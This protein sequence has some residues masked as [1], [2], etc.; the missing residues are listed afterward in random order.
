[1]GYSA[2]ALALWAVN[3]LRFQFVTS[4]HIS[5]V[6]P[7]AVGLLLIRDVL[8]I[9]GQSEKTAL[10]LPQKIVIGLG[11]TAVLAAVAF[12]KL[13]P[14]ASTI[15]LSDGS[16]LTL[17]HVSYEQKNPDVRARSWL[18]NAQ[19]W[20]AKKLDRPT[21][22]RPPV[23]NDCL[24]YW[25]S[26][27]EK[28]T[29]KYLGFDW[30]SHAV[31]VDS[32]GCE[33]HTTPPMLLYT[34]NWLGGSRPLPQ[35]PPGAKYL[36]ISGE[37]PVFPRREKTFKLRVYGQR[38][39]LAGEFEVSNPM[40][41]PYP[42]WKPEDLPITHSAGDLTTTLVGLSNRWTVD[43]HDGLALKSY[44]LTP[45]LQVANEWELNALGVEDAT[46]NRGTA[47]SSLALEY[48]ERPPPWRISKDLV[49]A[50]FRLCTNE[51]AWKLHAT[52][53]RSRHAM[54]ASNETWTIPNLEI[55]A[56]GTA[57]ILSLSNSWQGVTVSLCAVAGPGNI[58]YSNGVPM[59]VAAF[60]GGQHG[61]GGNRIVGGVEATEMSIT[62]EKPQ[63]MLHLSG[64]NERSRFMAQARSGGATY[65]CSETWTGNDYKL[66]LLDV[67]PETKTV[68]L[69]FVLQH[70]RV[71]DFFIRPQVPTGQLAGR[72]VSS[73]IGP[74][75]WRPISW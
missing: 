70:P 42:T 38:L 24:V 34:D 5:S 68:D 40:Y 3:I 18:T 51:T 11:V 75:L 20:L 62:T 43:D 14:K 32:H 37:L 55:P 2:L 8:L 41:R 28:G 27:R 33:F 23:R 57:R 69:T 59:S 71:I 16:I 39:A 67:P 65:V 17:E 12:W 53:L 6:A 35:P 50:E 36:L 48:W 54:F 66:L 19:I 46:G 4:Q 15:R 9:D 30:L 7:A 61:S 26:R 45:Q 63:V 1:M 60:S 56:P 73:T 10:K 21:F 29:G 22:S 25:I 47:G 31:A 58:T 44:F 52:F 13:L 72:S 49:S 64:F 74:S